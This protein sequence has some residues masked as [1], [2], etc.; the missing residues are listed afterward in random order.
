M[1][2]NIF[3]PNMPAAGN[4]LGYTRPLVLGNFANYRENLQVNHADV[5][6]SDSGKHTFLTLLAQPQTPIPVTGAAEGG[7]YVTQINGQSVTFLQ[8]ESNFS[9]LGTAMFPYGSV[10]STFAVATNIVNTGIIIDATYNNFWGIL[11]GHSKVDASVNFVALV[12]VSKFDTGQACFVQP[13]AQ[14][15]LTTI[16]FPLTGMTQIQMVSTPA[17]PVA[18]EVFFTLTTF[19]YPQT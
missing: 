7:I 9:Q 15:G 18:T 5:N 14:F 19:Y 4:S 8:R 17:L 12:K 13:L 2:T 6:S 10:T 11:E 1:P 16:S 3:T